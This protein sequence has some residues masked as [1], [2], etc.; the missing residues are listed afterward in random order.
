MSAGAAGA[1]AAAAAQAALRRQHEEEESMTDYRP[2]E[3]AGFEFKILR[4]ATS[5]FKD[6]AFLQQTLTEEAKAGWTLVEKFDNGRVRLKRPVAA[7]SGD[8]S[9]SFDAYRTWAGI[10][11]NQ[12]ALRIIGVVLG[13]ILLAILIVFLSVAH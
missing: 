7:R 4:S 2:E 5:R 3:L 8:A 13:V 1:S 9:L 6:P 11:D 10:S 12:M